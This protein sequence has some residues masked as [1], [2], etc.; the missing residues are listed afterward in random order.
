V[1]N[2]SLHLAA[3]PTQAPNPYHKL[4]DGSTQPNK[5]SRAN[6]VTCGNE[7]PRVEGTRYVEGGESVEP[8]IHVATLETM[9]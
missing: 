9:S 8:S 3:A 4:P 5:L 1:K 2:K 6:P 7:A